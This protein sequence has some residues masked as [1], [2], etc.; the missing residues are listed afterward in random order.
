MLT[1]AQEKWLEHLSDMDSVEICPADSKA[2][3]KFLEIKRRI[4]SELGDEVPIEHRGSTSF[5]ISGQGE[6]DVYIPVLLSYL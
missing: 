5:G 4:Q 6:L 3:E 2:R 1:P